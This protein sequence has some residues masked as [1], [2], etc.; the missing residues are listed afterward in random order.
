MLSSG[1]PKGSS[2]AKSRSWPPEV[3]EYIQ[4]WILEPRSPAFLVSDPQGKVAAKGGDLSRYGLD[5]L[6]EGE[7]VTEQA[8]FLEGYLPLD[9]PMSLL[10]QV[11]TA[12]GRFADIHL[13]QIPD[14]DCIVLLDCSK[15]VTE[16]AQIEQ[17]LHQT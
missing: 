2:R 3:A 9:S 14:G 13:F 15:E 6:R 5:N 16:R 4:Y 10:S 1:S 17:A 7:S 11:E 8:Y 12:S